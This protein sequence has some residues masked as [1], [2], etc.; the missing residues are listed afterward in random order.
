MTITLS[1]LDEPRTDVWP[2]ASRGRPGPP[3]GAMFA[4]D[5]HGAVGP[6]LFAP[7]GRILGA[8]RPDPRGTTRPR[9]RRRHGYRRDP[10]ALLGAEVVATDMTRERLQ[11]GRVEAVRRGAVVD[12][13]VG[14]PEALPYASQSFDSVVSCL[15]VMLTPHHQTAANELLRVSMLGGRIGL[16]SWTPEGLMGRLAALVNRILPPAQTAALAPTL[17]GDEA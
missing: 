3:D 17:W 7:L 15:G 14:N 13:V 2:A 1:V 12:W 6:D 11:V 9:Y 8:R 10:A 16:L 5:D 4:F